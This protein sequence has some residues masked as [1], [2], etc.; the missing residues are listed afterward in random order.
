MVVGIPAKSTVHTLKVPQSR[1]NMR[2]KLT[3]FATAEAN[4][5]HLSL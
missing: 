3:K 4:A 2:S 5:L 1:L